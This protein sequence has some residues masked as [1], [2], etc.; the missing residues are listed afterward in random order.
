MADNARGLAVTHGNIF[1]RY[2]GSILT[3][4][5]LIF[6][7]SILQLFQPFLL[8]VAIDRL[9]ADNWSGVVWLALLQVGVLAIGMARLFYDTRVYARIYRDIAE[10]AVTASQEASLELTRITARAGMLREVVGFFEYTLPSSLRS[11][12]N[13]IGS[14]LLLWFLSKTVLVACAIAIVVMVIIAVGFSGRI[15]SLSRRTSDQQEREVDVIAQQSRSDTREHFSKLAR[16]QIATSDTEVIMFG[17]SNVVLT[18]V[19]LFALYQT[20]SV[21]NA[22][23]GT[24]FAVFSYVT[25]FQ[26]ASYNLPYTYQRLIRTLEITERVNRLDD[27]VED[28]AEEHDDR[29]TPKPRSTRR[30]AAVLAS[31]LALFGMKPRR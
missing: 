14:V 15:R 7:S 9:I 4:L 18:G 31:T 20:I 8:G 28:D 3:T 17:L 13:L 24:I 2:W 30:D 29:E 11:V 23:V 25:R 6:A 19:L 16:W 22:E 27:D 12:I 10:E 1:R 5:G 21:E 26:F